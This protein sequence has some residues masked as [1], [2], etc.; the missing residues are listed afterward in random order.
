M[1]QQLDAAMTLAV[2]GTLRRGERN[3][4]LLE[5][6]AFLGTGYVAGTIRYVPGTP[7]WPYAYPALL[8][9]PVGRVLVELYRLVD[10]RMLA[11]LDALEQF[12][13][14]DEAGSP[15]V[16]KVVP[17]IDGPTERASVY[18]YQGALDELGE[19]I[20]SGDWV[21]RHSDATAP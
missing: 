3:H 17:V 4:Q 13:P 20:A 6:A 12:D 19:P 15:Y 11:A 8:P 16:R 7:S 1:A 10:D 18:L 9:Q 2:Y 21:K 5:G 14:S